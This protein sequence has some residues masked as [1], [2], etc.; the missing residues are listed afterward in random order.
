MT[1][2]GIC[3]RYKAKKPV[4]IGRYASG[5]KRCQICEIYMYVDKLF[6]PCCGYR[7]RT[8]PRNLKYK[9]LLRETI[10]KNTIG[11][12]SKNISAV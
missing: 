5:Q 1:C 8:K 9:Q 12:V 6:C 10:Q 2:K 3:P 4:G 11:S 7:L